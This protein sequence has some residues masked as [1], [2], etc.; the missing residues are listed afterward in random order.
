MAR[1]KRK[2]KTPAPEMG[3]QPLDV[4]LFLQSEVMATHAFAQG[5]IVPESA[6]VAI[7]QARRVLA[8]EAGPGAEINTAAMART[9]SDLAALVAPARPGTLLLIE[10][11]QHQKQFGAWLGVVPLIRRLILLALFLLI[12][13]ITVSL[14]PKINY[15]HLGRG[16]FGHAGTEL[17]LNLLLLLFAS[18]LGATFSGLYTTINAVKSLQYDSI[19]EISFF[20]RF[21]MGLITGLFITEIIPIDMDPEGSGDGSAGAIGKVTMA[22][23]GGFSAHILYGI[24]TK[25]V[26][27]F[28]SMVGE[29]DDML[30]EIGRLDSQVQKQ[31]AAQ[32]AARDRE[33]LAVANE[34]PPVVAPTVIVPTP[35]VAAETPSPLPPPA[36]PA[37]SGIVDGPPVEGW[38]VPSLLERSAFFTQAHPSLA[39]NVPPVPR[40]QAFSGALAKYDR[41]GSEDIYDD[42]KVKGGWRSMTE[43]EREQKVYWRA[44]KN[45]VD[46]MVGN[47]GFR[48]TGSGN[49][50]ALLAQTTQ[51]G[52]FHLAQADSY[53]RAL[54]SLN[55]TL[56]RR[57]PVVA[58]VSYGKKKGWRSSGQNHFILIVGRS[59]DEK[60]QCYLFFDPGRSYDIG[61]DTTAN[62]LYIG[63]DPAGNSHPYFISGKHAK[64]SKDYILCEVRQMARK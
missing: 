56:A 50:I 12:G 8:G 40:A 60:G 63:K 18:G 32:A 24:L 15:E 34:A 4:Y 23:L 44:C 52:A 31:I 30:K 49:A 21:T 1:K 3:P 28:E 62:R 27:S 59:A 29:G 47:A 9:H 54:A 53:D 6:L 33:V 46:Y 58:G 61:S 17:L 42:A 5:K 19:E 7:R 20:V 38:E 64:S 35:A 11:F 55:D 14:S 51:N 41:G 26:K 25:M 16:M 48:D 2:P 45:T 43:L 36:P 37:H 39:R 57:I 13:L 10:R 22:V